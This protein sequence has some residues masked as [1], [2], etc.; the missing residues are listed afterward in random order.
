MNQVL[1]RPIVLF[2]PSGSGKSTLLKKLFAEFPDKFAFV[3]SHTT[4]SP[5]VGEKHGEAYYFVPKDEFLDLVKKNGFIEHA[6]FSGNYYGTSVQAVKDVQKLGKICILDIEINGVKQVKKT[7][8]NPRFIFISPPSL[9]VLKERLLNRGT[10][11]EESIK[12]RLETAVLEQEYANTPNAFD[13]KIVN[14]DLET[15]YN[16]L[17]SF[18][19]EE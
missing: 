17:R 18:I 5:R 2:G 16:S 6:Q 1:K 15:A 4:R 9:E 14:N 19:L 10:E 3:V 7:D 8:L 13:I 11:T 12:K